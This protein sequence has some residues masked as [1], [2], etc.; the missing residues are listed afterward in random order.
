MCFT[1]DKQRSFNKSNITSLF[2][3]FFLIEKIV[4]ERVLMKK[5]V[6]TMDRENSL[7]VNAIGICISSITYIFL[8]WINST[9]PPLKTKHTSIPE[10]MI[11]NES[12]VDRLENFNQARNSIFS[13]KNGVTFYSKRELSD[14]VISRV[15]AINFSLNSM[16]TIIENKYRKFE[17]TFK[18]MINKDNKETKKKIVNFLAKFPA[19]LSPPKTKKRVSNHQR[20]SSL[21][22]SRV[23]K[24]IVQPRESSPKHN[25]RPSLENSLVTSTFGQ[26]AINQPFTKA[27]GSMESE[28]IKDD[29]L[30]SVAS[31]IS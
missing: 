13:R 19:N 18:H 3:L 5:Y 2:V 4:V 27:V 30:S 14:L 9:Y 20:T 6:E 28:E 31:K 21:K 8:E 15:Q 29:S 11:D 23:S 7:L 25:K 10:I 24:K 17:V 12:V 22:K 16:K 26:A 1:D